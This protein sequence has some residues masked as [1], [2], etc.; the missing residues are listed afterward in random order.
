MNNEIAG[1]TV[2]EFKRIIDVLDPCMDDYLYIMDIP[3]DS[4]CISEDAVKRFR[5]PASRLEHAQ[6][7]LGRLV[8][9]EDRELLNA[10]LQRIVCQGQSFHNLQYRW[11][12][13]DGRPIWINCR[14]RVLFDDEGKA[15]FLLGCINEIGVKQKAD[16]LSG[17]L[18]AE[19]LQ[20]E[21]AASEAGRLGGF[22]IRF[23]IDNFKDINENKGLDYGDMIIAKTAECIQKELLPE[24]KLYRVVADEYILLDSGNRGPEE[25]AA[26]YDRIRHK[27]ERFIKERYYEVFYTI[28]AG[29]LELSQIENQEYHNLMKLSEF[30]LNEAKNR[31]RNQCYLYDRED[32]R[33]FLYQKELTSQLLQAVNHNF[34]GFEAYFQPIVD[35]KENRLCRA[36][37]LLRF[38][39]PALGKVSPAEFIPLLEESSLIIPV[40]RWVLEQAM[41][42]CARLQQRIPDFHVSVNLSYVQVLKSDVLEDILNGLKKYG[43]RSDS[44]AIELTE[45]GFLETNTFLVSFCKGLEEH[46]IPLVL[47]DFGTGYSNFHYLYHLNVHTV[48]IDR[49]FTASALRNSYERSLLRHMSAMVHDIDLKLCIEGIETE[50]ELE[51]IC[52]IEPDY[53]QG[54]YYGRPCPLGEFWERYVAEK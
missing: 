19:S 40:G 9:P 50:E 4:Y 12:G 45:S 1:I 22:L 54:Y 35:H 27:L 41:A 2:E 18:N 20:K 5:L 39:S 21:L 48:K 33:A 53:I 16:N 17:L 10:D 37:T 31:G 6:E 25:A 42:A 52:R 29:I 43:L 32:Y 47:D 46:G 26:L 23:G 44:I 36:E 49:S 7:C 8:Y 34:Q 30:A 24:Q 14:G 51:R 28:S 13:K 38:Y 11:L 3:N 15:K